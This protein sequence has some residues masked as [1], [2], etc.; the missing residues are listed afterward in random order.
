MER[1]ITGLRRDD[2]GSW[3]AELTCGHERST[4]RDRPP[5]DAPLEC[6]DCDR[7]ELPSG[8]REYRRTPAFTNDTLPAAL[9]S[10]HST[11][12]GVWGVIHVEAGRLHYRI[13]A[14]YHEEHVLAPGVVGVVLP[15]VEHEVEPEGAVR[16]CVAF[17]RRGEA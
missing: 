11:K 7:R 2:A 15:E 1:E 17:H 8:H 14:P 9:R 4:G 10:S 16:F 13:H 6:A 3:V 12:A 5:E